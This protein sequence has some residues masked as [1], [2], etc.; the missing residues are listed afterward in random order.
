MH[1]SFL[2]RYKLHYL[3]AIGGFVVWMLFF[4]EKDYFTQLKRKQ[5]LEDLHAK[6]EYYKT[7]I[8]E[9]RLQVEALDRDPAMLEKFAREKYFMK[10]DNEDVYI[11]DLPPKP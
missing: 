7:E 3:L 2:F 8:E 9:T 11:I 4:D 5:E 1:R 10:R 6:M